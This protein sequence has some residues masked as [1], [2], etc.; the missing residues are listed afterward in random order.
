MQQGDLPEVSAALPTRRRL[1]RIVDLHVALTVAVTLET[2]GDFGGPQLVAQQAAIELVWCHRA[3]SP[4][5]RRYRTPP[6]R[7]ARRSRG[8][9]NRGS[10]DRPRRRSEFRRRCRE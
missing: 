5:P 7:A 6:R 10:R 9:W 8:C 4:L 2:G 1:Q 3:V